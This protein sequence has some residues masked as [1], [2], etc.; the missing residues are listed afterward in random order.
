MAAIWLPSKWY[1]PALV[2]RAL[3][4]QPTRSASGSLDSTRPLPWLSA[5]ARA[6]SVD[7]GTSGLGERNGITAN[8]PSG[9]SCVGVSMGKPMAVSTSPA[10]PRPTPHSGV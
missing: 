8:E 4:S 6:G 10:V 3:I 5:K 2:R 1:Q 7:C 9:R